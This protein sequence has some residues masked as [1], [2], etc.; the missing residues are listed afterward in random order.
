MVTHLLELQ[1]ELERLFDLCNDKYYAG[2]LQKPVIIIQAKR[3]ASKHMGWCTLSKVWKNYQDNEF[4]FEIAI[5]AEY[6]DRPV[7]EICATLLHEMV[8]LHC[9]ENGVQDTSRD[10]RYHNKKFK[11]VAEQHGLIVS[12]EPSSGWS[13]TKLNDEAQVFINYVVRKEVFVLARE[14]HDQENA[15]PQRG[16]SIKYVCPLCRCIVRATSEVNIVCGDCSVDFIR[17]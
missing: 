12:R 6:L 8:H 15:N 9:V 1:S 13:S 17:V 3:R 7:V 10:G 5:T 16:N 4:F 2:T 14:R 11:G